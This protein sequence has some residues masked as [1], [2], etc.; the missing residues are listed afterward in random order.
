MKKIINIDVHKWIDANTFNGVIDYIE[1]GCKIKFRSASLIHKVDGDIESFFNAQRLSQDAEQLRRESLTIYR[2]SQH[3]LETLEDLR[4]AF[5]T[6]EEH[7]S[8]VAA[9]MIQSD[10]LN[11]KFR[12][13]NTTVDAN[14][15]ASLKFLFKN[16]ESISEQTISQ[17]QH[18]RTSKISE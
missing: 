18:E 5:V 1:D 13:L 12:A 4:R 11:E 16:L 17:L 2:R 6:L 14:F 15:L 8:K 10:S 3:V 9:N 7:R